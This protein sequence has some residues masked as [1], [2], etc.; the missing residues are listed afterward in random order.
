MNPK[1]PR[2]SNLPICYLFIGIGLLIMLGTL[3]AAV[4]LKDGI[5]GRIGKPKGVKDLSDGLEIS[6][7]NR[8]IESK[9]RDIEMTRKIYESKPDN[10]AIEQ[11]N[12]MSNKKIDSNSFTIFGDNEKRI[13]KL[14]D[15][16]AELIKERDDLREQLNARR[17]RSRS[18]GELFEDYGGRYF[19][20]GVLPLGLLS[21]FIGRFVFGGKLPERNP[22]SLTD[23]ERRSILFFA[24][25]IIFSAFGFFL[26]VWIL[27][28]M[29]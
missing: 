9:D 15:E 2:N 6:S 22:F 29:N 19:L 5:V 11:L 14:E 10:K 12:K 25:S 7:L 28:L 20:S 8:Q 18:F 4:L 13:K 26:F 27:I 24:F 23:F 1:P 17:N 16:K 3:I 21:L